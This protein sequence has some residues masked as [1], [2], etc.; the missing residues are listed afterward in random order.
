MVRDL[1][2]KI[3]ARAGFHVMLAPNGEEALTAAFAHDGP[4][5]LVIADI[6]M[7]R[8]SGRELVERLRIIRPEARALYISGYSPSVIAR[9]GLADSRVPLLEKPF[10]PETVM[11]AVRTV[12]ATPDDPN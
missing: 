2:Q 8:M 9:H 6:V 10:T 1:L 12:L 7:P 11:H 5:R 4:I 3:L